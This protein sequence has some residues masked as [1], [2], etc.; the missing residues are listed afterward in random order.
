MRIFVTGATGFIG[1][2]VVTELINAGHQV[3]GLARSAAG[4]QALAAAGAQVQRGDIAEADTLRR[5]IEGADG[6]IHTAFNHDFS[7]FLASCEADRHV[8]ATLAEALA[9]GHANPRRPLIITSATAAANTIAGEPARED[10]PVPSAAVFPRAATEEAA[11]AALARGVNVSI[12]RLPQVHDTR[13][14]G[15]ITE[16]IRLAREKGVSAYVGEGAN[17][18]TAGHVSDAARLYRLALEK[19]EPGAKYHAVA[20]EGIALREIA[21]VI[22]RGLQV[23]VRAVAPGESAAHFGWLD[24]FAPR[25]LPASSAQTRAQLGWQPQGPGLLEDLEKMRYAAA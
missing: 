13:K 24:K 3:T 11:A 8:I 17:R 25:D 4:A 14:Q 19:A 22:A 10:N 20:E 5:A 18:W 6:V 7:Q 12:V 1:A 2:A 21:Q 15:L 9:A 16:L 23:P